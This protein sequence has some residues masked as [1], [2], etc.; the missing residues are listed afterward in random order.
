M[1][2]GKNT[3]LQRVFGG[4]EAKAKIFRSERPGYD[5]IRINADA[6][7]HEFLL[8]HKRA[9]KLTTSDP[10]LI[11]DDLEDT[12]D[13]P[14]VFDLKWESL[15]FLATRGLTPEDVLVDWAQIFKFKSTT[16]GSKDPG[17]RPPQIGALHAIAAH[18]SVG[19]E[20]EPATVVLPTGTG[21]TDTMLAAQVYLCLKKTLV[22]VP[23]DALRVQISKKFIEL[24]ILPDTETVPRTITKPRVA[25]LR[26]GLK[27]VAEAHEILK[28]A[29]II[30]SLPN[31]LHESQPDAL[32]EFVKGCSDLIVDEAHHIPAKSWSAIRSHFESKRII[33]FTAT[34]FRRDG[35]RIDGKIIFNY[36]LGDAQKDE[37]YQPINLR[38]IAEYGDESE[39]DFAIATQALAV[40]RHDRETMNFDHLIMA[41]TKKKERAE[42]V[43]EI[44]RKLAPEYNPQVIYS[45]PGRAETNRRAKELIL[46]RGPNGSRIIIC[47]DMLGEGFDLPNL[48]IA[49]FH[50]THRSLA[51]SL[52]FIGRFTRSPQE[53]QIGEATAVVNIA[54]AETEGKLRALYAEGAEWDKIIRRLSEERI[55]S[56]IR[57]EDVVS[58]LKGSGDLHS[59]LSLWNLRPALSA[60]FFRTKV[61]QWKPQNFS[62]ILPKNAAYWHAYSE[63][64]DTLIAVVCRDLKID[65]GEY[66]SIYDTVFDII[67]L[68]WVESE[69]L[70]CIYTSDYKGLR[71]EQLAEAVTDDNTELISGEVIFN[72]LNNVNLPLVKNLGS[73][74]IGAISFTSYFGPNV[75]EG[76]ADIEK[77]ES[78]LSNIACV[79]YENGE[80]VLWGCASRRG[81][82]W[83]HSAGTISGW[84]EW[85]DLAWSKMKGTASDT[86]NVTRDFLRP[87]RLLA[88]HESHPIS[89]Q[90]GEQAQT[91]FN[92]RQFIVFDGEREPIFAIDLAICDVQDNGAIDFSVS[93]ESK[94]SVYRLFIHKDEPGGYS[95]THI[96]GPK[97]EFQVGQRASF[98][99]TEYLKKRDPFIIRYADGTYSYN[100][101][102]IPTNLSASMYDSTKFEIFD[103]SGIDLTKESMG[104]DISQNTIQYRTFSAFNDEYDLIINDDG[105]GEAA[106][107][108]CIKEISSDVLKLTL[109]HCK[110]AHQ[111]RISQDIRNFYT[112][113][114]QAQ[115]SVVVKHLG[116]PTLI[117]D[118]VRREDRWKLQGKTRILKGDRK[119]MSMLSE[120]SRRSK[121]EFEM[122]VVQPGASARDLTD[123]ISRLLG[124]TELYINKTT[125][126][127]LRVI[128]SK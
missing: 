127:T 4:L 68:R 80:R 40:L 53:S 52:Q 103:W 71:T 89:I 49:A 57:L 23:S 44:Y 6:P 86:P 87:Q 106:D 85:T 111:G 59:K 123:D 60:Q 95:H 37:Y 124:T 96:S 1:K 101:Y 8:R 97:V 116:I 112:L 92:D 110:G 125:Q 104:K 25:I 13:F 15:G 10:V 24:G 45:G 26:S 99:L 79:G 22:L 33:Q 12:E 61:A 64:E 119:L 118:L 122:V 63:P 69:N 120:K 39:K 58:S 113:C 34:P 50:D 78:Q 90:W 14:E 105:K 29:N 7:F 117:H 77:S 62:Q 2:I 81:K 73:S 9:H 70:L 54:D 72:V 27:S 48:K 94:S 31:S 20:F 91:K 65:W 76:L 93:S 121:L 84:I 74:R 88:H 11:S 126:G 43:A 67:V 83:Q 28:N 56:E 109:V 108:V 16:K 17:L 35:K 114:G 32:H 100:C 42:R 98:E 21:K 102:H 3:V 115:K 36:K 55:E 38:T 41:R 75:T 82:I 51:I 66:Q 30:I 18:F 107:L 5:V 47:V 19:S 46:D 128:L